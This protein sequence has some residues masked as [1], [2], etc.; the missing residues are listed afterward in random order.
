MFLKNISRFA[1][2]K[3]SLKLLKKD[4]SISGKLDM[5]IINSANNTRYAVK[6]E[7]KTDYHSV[8]NFNIPPATFNGA[9]FNLLNSQEY[10]NTRDW[11][12]KCRQISN[13]MQLELWGKVNHQW[14][15]VLTTNP[16]TTS[17]QEWHVA[18]SEVNQVC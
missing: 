7:I 16:E 11:W 9:S 18:T 1:T 8:R 10:L 12:F 2:A 13:E 15:L 14:I 17:N 3:G 6:L 5:I 4:K